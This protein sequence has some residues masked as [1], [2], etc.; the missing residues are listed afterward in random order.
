LS[1]RLAPP[2]P[3]A[4]PLTGPPPLPAFP[5]SPS[6]DPAS[7]L[8]HPTTSASAAQ[9]LIRWR[10][11]RAITIRAEYHE[12]SETALRRAPPPDAEERRE[13]ARTA[14]PEPDPHEDYHQGLHEH[15]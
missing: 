6:N 1:L 13:L 4:P 10:G 3:L 5:A 12:P 7:S 14:K 2:L 15:R 8:E 11:R 9:N